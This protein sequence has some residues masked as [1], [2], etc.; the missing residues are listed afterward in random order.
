MN[1]L[2]INLFNKLLEEKLNKLQLDAI[3]KKETFTESGLDVDFANYNFAEGKVKAYQE[4][5]VLLNEVLV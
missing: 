2:V 1:R 5:C 3:E 4:M